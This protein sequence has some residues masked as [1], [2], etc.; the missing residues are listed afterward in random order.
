MPPD[1]VMSAIGTDGYSRRLRGRAVDLGGRRLL[2]SDLRGSA[3]EGDLSEPVNCGGYGR[4]RHFTRATETGWPDNPLP[5]DPA[6]AALGLPPGA[7]GI[8]AQVFQNA[9][10]NWHCVH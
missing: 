4:I 3:Q 2:V 8:R 9:A 6:A 10:C 7:D 5:T 1:P